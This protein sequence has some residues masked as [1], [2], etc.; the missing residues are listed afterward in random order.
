MILLPFAPLMRTWR[1]DPSM[2]ELA[3]RHYSRRKPGA[4]QF[5]GNGSDRGRGVTAVKAVAE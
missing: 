4:R 1:A 2:V 3:D 5:A